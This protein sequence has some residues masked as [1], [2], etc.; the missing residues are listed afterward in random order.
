MN[1][2]LG[3]HEERYRGSRFRAMGRK[4]CPNCGA[5]MSHGLPGNPAFRVR[6]PCELGVGSILAGATD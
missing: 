4:R 5:H 2:G 1:H 6:Q 3:L